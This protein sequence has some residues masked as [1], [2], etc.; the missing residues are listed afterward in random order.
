MLRVSII[1]AIV[2]SLATG[3]FAFARKHGP[4]KHQRDY[5]AKHNYTPIRKNQVCPPG[6]RPCG[7]FCVPVDDPCG[8]L[9]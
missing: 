8:P 1:A 5:A 6:T 4:T 7:Y 3:S 9:R 2:A